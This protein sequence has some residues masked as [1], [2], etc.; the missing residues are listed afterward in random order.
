M[1]SF[2]SVNGPSR[3]NRCCADRRMRVPFVLG[4]S[5]SPPIIVFVSRSGA[6]YAPI[7]AIDSEVGASPESRWARIIATYRCVFDLRTGGAAGAGGF[8]SGGAPKSC[9]VNDSRTSSVPS[10]PGAF[11]TTSTAAARDGMFTIQIA[12][13]A[14]VSRSTTVAAG[15]G[16]SACS[17]TVAPSSRSCSAPSTFTCCSRRY[18]EIAS[19]SA[20]LRASALKVIMSFTPVPPGASIRASALR[21][22]VRRDDAGHECLRRAQLEAGVLLPWAEQRQAIAAD[23]RMEREPPLRTQS[24]LVWSGLTGLFVVANG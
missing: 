11:F 1:S 4:L 10:P 7:F 17:E 2:D 8:G 19:M 12:R 20:A 15:A 5:P 13:N 3:M 9:G 21:Q 18:I 16:G 23:H 6:Q 22:I 14:E 24:L